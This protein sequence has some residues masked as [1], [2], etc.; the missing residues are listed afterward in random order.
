M[1]ATPTKAINIEVFY[2]FQSPYCYVALDRIFKLEEDFDVKLLWQIF[3][4]KAA[5]QTVPSYPIVPEKLLY[6]FDDTKR[7]AKELGMDIVFPEGWPETEFDPT[8][9]SR[10]ALIA[11]DLGITKEYIY[12]VFMH[13]WG[14]GENPNE[15]N[16]MGELCEELDIDQGEFL[17]KMSSSDTRERVKGIYKRGKK[18][19]VYDTPTF[20]IDGELFVGHDKIY[21][22]E[23]RLTKMGLKNSK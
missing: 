1:T 6:L 14:M 8:R 3:S 7:Y 12:K 13:W 15:P 23:E 4:A 2:S 22:L 21:Y 10:G 19:I 11:E 16:F 5:G 9:V 18:F 20:V 17:S